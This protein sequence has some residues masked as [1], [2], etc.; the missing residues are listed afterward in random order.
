M[1]VPIAKMNTLTNIKN[2][3]LMNERELDMGLAGTKN[4]WHMEYRVRINSLM[5]NFMFF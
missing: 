3:N 4:S 5:I 1:L 2:L